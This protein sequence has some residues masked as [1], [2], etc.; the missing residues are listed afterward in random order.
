MFE[1][2]TEQAI[3]SVMLAQEEA[4][5]IGHN[6]VGTEQ[7]LLGLI[8][9]G[10]GIGPTVLKQMGVNLKTTRIEV[11][12]IIGRGS[13]FVSPEIPFTPRAK[14]NLEIS[15]DEARAFGHDY[16]GT[17]H[18]LLGIIAKPE[19]GVAVTVLKS[20]KIDFEETRHRIIRKIGSNSDAKAKSV[21]KESK[22]P[23]LDDFSNDLT[24]KAEERQLDPVVGRSQEIERVVQILGRRSKNNPVLIGEPGVGKTAVAEGLAQRIIDHDIP[25]TLD[26]KSII[27]LDMGLLISGTKYRGEFEERLKKILTEI[28]VAKDIILLIDE[29]H[30]LVGAGGAEGAIDAANIIK[31]ALSR[32][33][34]QCIG[35]TTTNEYRA[36]IEKDPAL[37]RRFQPVKVC[38]PSV[39]ETIQILYG[40]R[41]RYEEHHKLTISDEAIFASANFSDQ[42]IADRFLPDKAI[43]LMDEAGS[44]VHLMN[45]QLPPAAKELSNKLG[46][47]S[48]LKEEAIRNQDFEGASKI[49]DEETVI[50]E[51]IS[52][53][54]SSGKVAKNGAPIV[55]EED[56][57]EI[58]ASW[59]SIPVNKLTKS[60]SDKLLQ[61]EETL[62]GRIIGQDEAVV[63][64]SKA[65][66][67]ARVGLKSPDRPIASFIFSGPTGV[68]K[69]E[70]TKALALY[71][72]GA[73]EAMVRLDMSEY[74]ERHTVSKLIGSPPGYVGYDDGGQL[75]EAVRSRPYTVVLF[76][77]IEK[78]H[79]DVFN[80]LLQI[81]DDGH[82]TDSKGRTVSF[83]NTLLILTSNIG[84]KA[85]EKRAENP[86]QNLNSNLNP[87]ASLCKLVNDE[88]KLY[89]RPEFLNRLDEIIVFRRLTKW[90]IG[91]IAVLMLKEVAN[92]LEEKGIGL[93]ATDQFKDHL[94]NEG[95]N[96]SYGARPLRRALMNLLE[97]R[98]A[99]LILSGELKEGDAVVADFTTSK[100]V[101]M[102]VI[103]GSEEGIK[104]E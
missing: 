93:T 63:A 69:T 104:T 6:W 77:E 57:A 81:F 26:G 5:R 13:G 102:L 8:S 78:A 29:I 25:N 59:T 44:R 12:K 61:M 66:R 84:S 68:G 58:V 94:I 37:E 9:E 40:L 92:R 67:R 2:F 100:K 11:E 18:L 47:K 73:E 53:I 36:H 103:H 83:K 64:V 96:P 35:A 15:L 50:R 28:Q 91:E 52:G 16:I 30:T 27:S 39:D 60:E 51:R 22:T 79:P 14:R 54:V 88:L 31:P 99:E 42:Y 75:T 43:D 55:T 90:E 101:K 80:L 48:K 45:S 98:L 71:F 95:Y 7:I 33:Q 38:E 82:L 74:M 19:E 76:D 87:Y 97:D 20:M 65:I 85:I 41:G 23:I 62:H 10:T 1:R 56:I 24:K 34:F 72:F 3:K 21:Q 32:G 70:L 4:K 89:F 46:K 86:S 17:E 49:R